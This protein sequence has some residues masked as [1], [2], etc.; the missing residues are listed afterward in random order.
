M[1]NPEQILLNKLEDIIARL[2]RIEQRQIKTTAMVEDVKVH[3]APQVGSFGT[4]D[5]GDKA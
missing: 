3:E 4:T 5:P 1:P 2:E